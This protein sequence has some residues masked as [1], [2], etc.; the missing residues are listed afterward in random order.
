M[1]GDELRK[2]RQDAGLSQEKVSLESGVDRS[3][4]SELE[5]NRWSPTVDML[6]RICDALK[7]AASEVL[8]RVERE[9]R[10]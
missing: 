3:Y 6:F 9:R 2:V 8:A 1:L 10:K 5:N 7:I 4:L